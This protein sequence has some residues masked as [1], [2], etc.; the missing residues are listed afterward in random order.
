MP[1][2]N[3][4]PN[5]SQISNLRFQICNSNE[6]PV[7]KTSLSR[8]TLLR[9]LGISMAL[10]LLDAMIPHGLIGSLGSEALGAVGKA[11]L[12]TAF[13][14]LPNGMWMPNFT[15]A[16]TGAGFAI[17]PTLMPLKNL[18]KEFSILSGLSLDA[19]RAHGDGPGDHARS[20]AA[21]L[22]GVH[23]KKTGG[24]DI[25]LGVSVDQGAAMKIRGQTP[26]PP[27]QPWSDKGKN[28]CEC[29]SR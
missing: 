24:S 5:E 12:R 6:V 21:F 10:P 15:P 1:S 3:A 11:P 9:G 19:A 13:V 28:P 23:P 7:S 16:T 26:F 27:L 18:A 25:H 29:D 22:T 14:F 8:R 4:V 17:T 20:A 2:K